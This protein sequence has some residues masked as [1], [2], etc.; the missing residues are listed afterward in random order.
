MREKRLPNRASAIIAK[1][2]FTLSGQNWR[3]PELMDL[4][5]LDISA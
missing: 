5:H 1:T 4:S 2:L 3:G